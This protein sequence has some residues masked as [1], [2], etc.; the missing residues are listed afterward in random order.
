MTGA[1]DPAADEARHHE[2]GPHEGRPLA[3]PA[4]EA[5]SAD[6]EVADEASPLPG[7]H[8]GGFARLPTAPIAV[9]SQ[10][11]PAEPG[12]SDDPLPTATWLVPP[13]EEPRRGVA[14]WALAF[15][16]I[17]LV[18]S[19]FVGWGFPIGLVGVIT[20]IL[21]L[22]RPL[23]SRSVAIWALVIGLVSLLY[24]AAWLVWAATLLRG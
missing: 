22:R 8:R 14:G 6:V 15:S 13:P 21:A 10:T 4:V 5:P 11:A 2:G 16:I 19:M 3:E 20:A 23:E 9:T 12:T 18:V 1:G 17:G 7:V 24:S